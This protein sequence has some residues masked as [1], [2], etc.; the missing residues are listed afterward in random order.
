M[1]D[2]RNNPAQYLTGPPPLNVTG[3]NRECPALLTVD[4][5]NDCK[6]YALFLLYLQQLL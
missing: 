5:Y 1:T 6:F 2:I 4:N 3:Y